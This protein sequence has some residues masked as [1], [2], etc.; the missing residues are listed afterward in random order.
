MQQPAKGDSQFVHRVFIVALAAVFSIAVL[1]FLKHVMWVL[2][3]FFAGCLLGVLLDGAA[4]LLGQRAPISR[5][6]ALLTVC[7]LGLGVVVAVAWSI[8]PQI[9]E[10]MGELSRR[11]PQALKEVRERLL[12]YSW[13][14]SVLDSVPRPQRMIEGELVSRA[15]SL[16]TTA[17][18]A[19]MNAVIIVFIGIYLAVSP[20]MHIL[21]AVH[22]LPPRHRE[23]GYLV[24]F[25]LGRAL[26]RWLLG[27]LVSMTVIGVLTGTSLWLAKVPLAL[28]L[29][30]IAALLSFIPYI[31]PIL[32]AV[33]AVII[34][35][36]DSPETALYVLL[37]YAAVQFVESYLVDPIV[38]RVA[39]LIPPAFL[40]T[41]QLMAGLWVGFLG[42]L[43]AP[44]L[45]V[46][47]TV[48]V[49]MLYLEDIL[50]DSPEVIGENAA[51]SRENQ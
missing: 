27:R 49:Q 6:W 12:H 30:L 5:R 21:V 32:S 25:M 14:Q 10:Q 9:A 18:G 17:F 48:L 43:L 26:R 13:V 50:G 44:P 11:L 47:I 3:V 42:V 37:I 35:L 7:L 51:V 41:L 4:R 24:F 46:V 34:G 33:P 1:Y 40:I 45:A 8:G 22:L 31:G 38:E 23:R 28:P 20:R 36:A 39:V 19:V 16:F 2:L 15:T 29:A